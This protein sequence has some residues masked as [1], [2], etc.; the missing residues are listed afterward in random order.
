MRL[1]SEDYF[2]LRFLNRS[3][4]YVAILFSLPKTQVIV[5]VDCSDL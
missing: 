1:K 5:T 3:F 4:D 2:M